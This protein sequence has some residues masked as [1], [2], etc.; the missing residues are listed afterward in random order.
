M[1]VNVDADDRIIVL[2][3]YHHRL[4]IYN[5]LKDYE[6]LNKLVGARQSPIFALCRSLSIPAHL[7]RLEPAIATLLSRLHGADRLGLIPGL[8][9]Q[10]AGS[11]TNAYG[12]WVAGR[13]TG[14]NPTD[15]GKPRSKHRV[16]TEANGTTPVG[17]PE[18]G[19][20]NTT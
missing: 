1:A 14:P 10:R 19:P 3:S 11:L 13:K 20:I 7:R 6:T 12:P 18:P 4:Q 15:R 17:H 2:E 5:K 16:L 9:G 8:R